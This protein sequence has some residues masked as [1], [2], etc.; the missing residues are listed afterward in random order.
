M[1]TTH[2]FGQKTNSVS[3]FQSCNE[4][5]KHCRG[6]SI[7]TPEDPQKKKKMW[8]NA[9]QK[10]KLFMLGTSIYFV[11][12]QCQCP[13]FVP[14]TPVVILYIPCK[15]IMY[16]ILIYLTEHIT[17]KEQSFGVVKGR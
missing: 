14:L 16:F 1:C 5:K 17:P 15:Q 6:G 4:F 7:I 9:K 12:P 13:C 11:R 8:G 2:R 3:M 10:A